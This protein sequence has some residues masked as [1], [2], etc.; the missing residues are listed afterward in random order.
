MTKSAT[1]LGARDSH[2]FTIKLVERLYLHGT[3]PNVNVIMSIATEVSE[4]D[5]RVYEFY[6]ES[7]KKINWYSFKDLKL[8]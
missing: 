3:F 1:Y 4:D 8:N 5:Y 7:A 2:A 6:I